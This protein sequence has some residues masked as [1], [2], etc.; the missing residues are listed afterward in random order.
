M[1]ESSFH[2]PFKFFLGSFLFM[3][4]FAHHLKPI[5]LTE[6]SSDVHIPTDE[7]LLRVNDRV[8]VVYLYI[9]SNK[10]AITG[11]ALIVHCNLTSFCINLLTDKGFFQRLVLRRPA[12]GRST[13][14]RSDEASEPR[15]SPFTG[16]M[17][18]AQCLL[19]H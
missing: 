8:D 11:N 10:D 14:R 5:N 2:F 9:S 17:H 12:S 6:H 16:V 15:V 4:R 3:A 1:V 19:Q 13:K 7:A 18:L